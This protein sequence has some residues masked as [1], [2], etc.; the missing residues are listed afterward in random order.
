MTVEI[1]DQ[2]RFDSREYTELDVEGTVRSAPH[3]WRWMTEGLAPGPLATLSA[4]ADNLVEPTAHAVEHTLS[5][6][7]RVLA[8]L[9]VGPAPGSTGA[10]AGLF[11]S[12]GG[13]P[14]LPIDAAV[15]GY[16][17]V[18]GDRQASRQHHGRVWQALC[19]WSTDVVEQLQAEGH[20]ITPGAAGEN[21]SIA[22]L[23]W[24]AVRPGVRLGLGDQVLIEVSSYSPP[25]SKNAQWFVDRDFHRIDHDRHPGWSRVY[26]SVRG[27]GVV[28]PGDAVVVEP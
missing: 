9:A 7:G 13:V 18:D 22:G 28:R 2:C 1:C 25:C 21:I 8:G 12:G 15:I 27:D 10:I 4:L 11:G 14:K 19:L 20:P 26:A 3:R 23:D 17:G 24:Q 5:E 6:A 16:R